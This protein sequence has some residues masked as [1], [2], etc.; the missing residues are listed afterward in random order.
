MIL[1]HRILTAYLENEFDNGVRGVSDEIGAFAASSLGLSY[2]EIRKQIFE[3][4]RLVILELFEVADQVVIVSPDTQTD[5]T[6]SIGHGGFVGLLMIQLRFF[7]ELEIPYEVVKERTNDLIAYLVELVENYE[8][9]S[10][11]DTTELTCDKVSSVC[12]GGEVVGFILQM[13]F[14]SRL[15]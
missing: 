5:G 3:S 8:N 2:R 15:G 6:L 14:I 10:V 12:F 1:F 4:L 11:L 9:M 13:R 7:S